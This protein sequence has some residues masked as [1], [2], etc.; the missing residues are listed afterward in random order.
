MHVH[1]LC[2]I[3]LS[4]ALGLTLAAPAQPVWADDEPPAAGAD[5]VIAPA[6]VAEDVPLSPIEDAD[7]GGLRVQIVGTRPLIGVHPREALKV[8]PGSGVSL[9]MKQLRRART[10]TTLQETLRGQAGVHIRDEVSGGVVPNIGFRGLNPD[11]SESVLILEDG[12]LGGLRAVHRQRGVLHARRASAS[13]AIEILKGSG[14][15]LLRTAHGRPRAEPDLARHPALILE[16]TPD[17]HRRQRTGSS[18]RTSLYGATRGRVRLSSS[19]GLGQASG[20]RLPR[21][22][23]ASRSSTSCSRRRYAVLA[24]QSTSPFKVAGEPTATAQNTYL[25]LTSRTSS[26]QDPY[27]NPAARRYVR[28]RV[29]QRPGHVAHRTSVAGLDL[30]VNVYAA[31]GK[32]DWDRQDFA[33]NAGFAPRTRQHGRRRWGTRRSTEARSTCAASFGSRDRDSALLGRRAAPH[34]HVLPPADART[35]TRSAPASTTSTTRTSATTRP[36]FLG[37]IDDARS[38]YQRHP[39]ALRVRPGQ[40]RM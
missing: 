28:D 22:Q 16:A 36:T 26:R 40:P 18:R 4:M 9:D 1:R 15:I 12:V 32:R 25:G 38:R 3:A 6:A 29:V 23:R 7:G 34:G 2:L 39:G 13:R 24:A 19:R 17:R 33:R 8:I 20:G 30:V 5:D 37:P 31:G 14:Q 11:R 35:S 21:P 10:A 27:Q